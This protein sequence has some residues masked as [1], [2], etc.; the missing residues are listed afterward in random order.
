MVDHPRLLAVR[1]GVAAAQHGAHAGQEFARAHRL[2]HIVVGAELQADHAVDL[3]A[4]GAH[5]DDGGPI[6]RGDAAT[7]GEAV[8]AGQHEVEHDQVH[9]RRG[10]DAVQ[11]LGVGGQVGLEAVAGQ[12][13][14][15]LV[16]QPD[17]V[18]HDED[19]R[20]GGSLGH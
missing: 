1:R 8:L 11:L 12:I 9:G 20:R 2:G 15:D 18:L 17:I 3:L 4:H 10:Q 13:L 7:D 14:C 16:A 6:G 5:D 19:L